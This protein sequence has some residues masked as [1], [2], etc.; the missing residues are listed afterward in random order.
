[1]TMNW[2]YKDCCSGTN[3]FNAL[4][5]HDTVYCLWGGGSNI[6][7]EFQLCSQRQQCPQK[8]C[9]LATRSQ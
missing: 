1:M 7:Q 6:F 8:Q 2:W 5:V 3:S 4:L 9:H